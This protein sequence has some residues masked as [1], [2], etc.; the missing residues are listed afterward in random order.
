MQY[1][2]K[3]AAA[4]L[5]VKD[6]SKADA[7]YKRLLSYHKK[8]QASDE[9]KIVQDTFGLGCSAAGLKRYSEAKPLLIS[10]I[11]SDSSLVV[12]LDLEPQAHL[13]YA[14]LLVSDGDIDRARDVSHADSRHANFLYLP[15][16]SPESS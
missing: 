12:V 9:G 11:N 15:L 6:Y 3:L 4:Y 13:E 16:K 1:L 5:D 8:A 2:E 10:V 14:K 7:A